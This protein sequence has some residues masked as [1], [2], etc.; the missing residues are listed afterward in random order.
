MVTP[1]VA[2]GIEQRDNRLSRG[3]NGLGSVSATLVTVSAGE[4]QILGVIAT[5]GRLRYD[6]IQCEADELPALVR[7]AVFASR[8]CSFANNSSRFRRDRHVG[9][10]LPFA[11]CESIEPTQGV[12]QG[13]DRFVFRRLLGVE[14]ALLPAFEKFLEL[15][16]QWLTGLQHPIASQRRDGNRAVG[17]TTNATRRESLVRKWVGRNGLNHFRDAPVEVIVP[18]ETAGVNFRFH[19]STTATNFGNAVRQHRSGSFGEVLGYIEV[20]FQ[21]RVAVPIQMLRQVFERGN[22]SDQRMTKV[23]ER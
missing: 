1:F 16:L 12:V 13:A 14:R 7:M 17:Q 15:R 23:L 8:R 18:T 3:I 2:T 6:M 9:L 19:L 10:S 11:A 22:A 20:A 21:E 5:I 4:S